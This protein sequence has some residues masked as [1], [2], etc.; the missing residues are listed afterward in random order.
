M[1]R[2][3]SI[4]PTHEK[5]A[6]CNSCY[7]QNYDSK[8]GINIGRRVERL[9]ELSVGNTV[10]TFCDECLADLAAKI[11]DVTKEAL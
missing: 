11:N 1:K 3:L 4:R 9:W 7:A 2:D 5:I 8:T 10:V 6:S